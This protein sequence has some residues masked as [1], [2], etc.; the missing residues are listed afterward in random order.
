MLKSEN[1]EKAMIPG[2]VKVT[3]AAALEF[4]IDYMKDDQNTAAYVEDLQ[5]LLETFV[6]RSTNRKPGKREREM[7]ERRETIITYLREHPDEEFSIDEIY[8]ETRLQ[9]GEP[10]LRQAVKAGIVD[11]RK[12]NGYTY[13]SIHIDDEEKVEA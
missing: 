7:A 11:K 6:K 2:A 5:Q 10:T 3:H 9:V 1:V 13:F 12:V 4:A 8:G